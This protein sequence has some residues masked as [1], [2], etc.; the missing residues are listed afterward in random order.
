MNQEDN[1]PDRERPFPLAI[2]D[3]L[4]KEDAPEFNKELG[5]IARVDTDIHPM[6]LHHMDH[7]RSHPVMVGLDKPGNDEL[8][9][10]KLI[11]HVRKQSKNV[12]VIGNPVV[13]LHL[14]TNQVHIVGD[15][16]EKKLTQDL[17]KEI[18]LLNDHFPKPVYQNRAARRKNKKR[19]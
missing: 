15:S 1:I 6:L 10:D 9:H 8:N 4:K 19:K 16:F 2:M 18:N 11:E 5:I 17:K 3:V 12:L 7:G 13:D 14:H